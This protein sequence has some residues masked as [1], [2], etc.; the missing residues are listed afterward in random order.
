LKTPE[1][2]TDTSSFSSTSS[3]KFVHPDEINIKAVLTNFQFRFP[4]QLEQKSADSGSDEEEDDFEEWERMQ[5]LNRI[6]RQWTSI[7]GGVLCWPMSLEEM[8]R[9]V[10]PRGDEA[11][12]DWSIQIW[13]HADVGHLLLEEVECWTG[14]LPVQDARAMKIFW[15]E[16][17]GMHYL[18]VQGITIIETRVSVLNPGFFSV[19][20]PNDRN[21][22]IY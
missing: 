16:F 11:M 18:L 19:R 20:P 15:K 6:V 10:C 3:Q 21:V 1:S 14:R 2:T 9:D 5:E 13:E 8:F 7:W 17:Q 4:R 12:M 22:A